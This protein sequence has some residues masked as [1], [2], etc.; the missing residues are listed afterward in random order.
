MDWTGFPDVR[1]HKGVVLEGNV[2]NKSFD[3]FIPH[4]NNF[5]FHV[6]L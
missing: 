5:F 2:S 3:Y 4:F 1:H 6:T